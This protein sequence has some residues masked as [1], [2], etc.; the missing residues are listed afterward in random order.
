[1]KMSNT[2]QKSAEASLLCDV[3][4]NAKMG[5]EAIISL[6]PAVKDE[7]F[8]V[9]LTAELEKYDEIAMD[10][11]KRLEEMNEEP[12]EEG[13]FSRMMAKMGI[14]MNTLMDGTTSHFAQMISEG[15]I[16]GT[17]DLQKR[18]NEGLDY[19]EAEKL[20]KQLISFEEDTIK[21]M[22]SYL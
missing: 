11:K 20:A 2:K 5:A 13:T 17:T 14:K 19:G 10:A 21:R 16:M 6:L 3:Y 18:L 7:E 9:E 8:K 22:K 15:C 12:E 1:M 4:R